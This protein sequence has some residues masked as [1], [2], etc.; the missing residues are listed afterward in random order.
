M[1]Q[2]LLAGAVLCGAWRSTARSAPD[3]C[4][5]LSAKDASTLAGQPLTPA[6]NA[7]ATDCRFDAAGGPGAG[8]VEIHIRVDASAAQAHADFPRWVMP[9]AMASMPQGVPLSGIGDEAATRQG[10]VASGIYIRKG[11]TLVKIGVHPPVTDIARLTAA[12][13]A[14]AARM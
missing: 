6:A 11:A 13:T 7:S 10:P 8:G 14:A 12:A 5:L 4:T 1:R 2:V 3:A 9:V